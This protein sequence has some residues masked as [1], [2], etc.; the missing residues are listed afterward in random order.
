LTLFL[1]ERRSMTIVFWNKLQPIRFFFLCQLK[2]IICK[3][4]TQLYFTKFQHLHLVFF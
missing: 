2:E 1:M 3:S 4:Q